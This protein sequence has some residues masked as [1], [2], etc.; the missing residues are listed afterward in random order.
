MNSPYQGAAYRTSASLSLQ[1]AEADVAASNAQA[2]VID[3]RQR[4]QSLEAKLAAANERRPAAED[5]IDADL[6]EALVA[7]PDCEPDPA[8]VASRAEAHG[9]AFAAWETDRAI[10]TE[11]IALIDSRL[12]TATADAAEK[13]AAR[14]A[15]YGEFVRVSHDALVASFLTGFEKLKQAYLDP[16]RALALVEIGDRS[17][18]PATSNKLCRASFVRLK[19]YEAGGRVMT[20]LLPV[21][22]LAD[23][24]ALRGQIDVYRAALR[25]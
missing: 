10:I 11:G 12:E 1:L 24:R 3:L 4:R 17:A 22:S 2:H 15:A 5:G 19:R 13:A 16:A 21:A 18:V 6:V 20:D 25:D 7:D 8:R 23:E 14:D 9:R